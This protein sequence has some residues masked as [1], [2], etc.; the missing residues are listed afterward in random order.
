MTLDTV[1]WEDLFPLRYP[2]GKCRGLYYQA[3]IQELQAELFFPNIFSRK[4]GFCINKVKIAILLY[5]IIFF[6]YVVIIILKPG[7]KLKY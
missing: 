6:N 1:E 3:N 2:T 4:L 5:N 7:Y